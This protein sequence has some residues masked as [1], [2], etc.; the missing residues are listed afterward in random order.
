[1]FLFL[2]CM[3]NIM[4]ILLRRLTMDEL[5]TIKEASKITKIGPS[6]LYTV[7]H[8]DRLPY[9]LIGNSRIVILK[10]DLEKWMKANTKQDEQKGR[11]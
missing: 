3:N 8:F 4:K 6:T 7:L 1:M 2:E 11:R 5:L 9:K 10:E